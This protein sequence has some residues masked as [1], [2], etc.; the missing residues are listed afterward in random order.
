MICVFHDVPQCLLKYDNMTV[1]EFQVL[2]P[3]HGLFLDYVRNQWMSGFRHTPHF[4]LVNISLRLI[5]NT[6]VLC[7]FNLSV[8]P[9]STDLFTKT[10][11]PC[12]V[13]R[14]LFFV[15]NHTAFEEE[16][17]RKNITSRFE[18]H[19]HIPTLIYTTPKNI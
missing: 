2:L 1:S 17:Q 3:S 8:P 13:L 6:T 7:N 9:I 11:I 4:W 18:K 5:N 15:F 19:E 10:I 14:C 12:V 16:R